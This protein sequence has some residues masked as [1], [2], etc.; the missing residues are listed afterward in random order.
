M[1][2]GNS[3]ARVVVR[4]MTILPACMLRLIMVAGIGSTLGC[5]VNEYSVARAPFSP[6]LQQGDWPPLKE[7]HRFPGV[8][9]TEQSEN[10]D[11]VRRHTYYT[12]RW[13]RSGWGFAALPVE[14]ERFVLEVR[15]GKPV[16][17]YSF[18]QVVDAH[19]WWALNI[20]GH[21]NPSGSSTVRQ[22]EAWG[23]PGSFASCPQLSFDLRSD[24]G[25]YDAADPSDPYG[26]RRSAPLPSVPARAREAP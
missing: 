15:E 5:S 21:G 19:S 25:P 12:G 7:P 26:L 17:L 8:E 24:V 10:S 16:A 11:G 6:W 23:V 4:S 18:V 2:I 14:R 3:Q 13:L 20:S 9:R 22:C 1:G